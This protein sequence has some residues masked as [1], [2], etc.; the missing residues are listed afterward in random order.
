MTDFTQ[1]ARIHERGGLGVPLPLP[2]IDDSNPFFDAFRAYHE[3]EASTAN[4]AS[5]S[6][7]ERFTR[8]KLPQVAISPP[9]QI[10]Q[11]FLQL[12]Q[13]GELSPRTAR[14]RYAEEMHDENRAI[15]GVS[16]NWDEKFRLW[17][18]DIDALASVGE[19][20]FTWRD[21]A[22]QAY[23]RAENARSLAF[24][25]AP[26]KAFLGSMVAVFTDP[27]NLAAAG[28]SFALTGGIGLPA[29]M[30]ALGRT[31]LKVGVVEGLTNLGAEELTMRL[32]EENR[33][34]AGVEPLTDKEKNIRRAAAGA[35]G[36]VL[37]GAI[38]AGIG[39]RSVVRA[40][41]EVAEIAAEEIKEIDNGNYKARVSRETLE[42]ILVGEQKAA[43]LIDA[44]PTDDNVVDNAKGLQ[45]LNKAAQR[46]ENG[47]PPQVAP[48]VALQLQ[49][50]VPAEMKDKLPLIIPAEEIPQIQVD[51]QRFQLKD[52][53]AEGVVKKGG[54][55]ASRDFD[56]RSV[57]DAVIWVDA[58]GT[59]FIVD[60][61]QRLARYK[62]WVAEGRKD[63]FMKAYLLTESAGTTAEDAM[64]IAST[65]NLNEGSVDTM[66]ATKWLRG[67]SPSDFEKAVGYLPKDQATIK[68]S[69]GMV[70]LGREAFELVARGGYIREDMAA[71]VGARLDDPDQQMAALREFHKNPPTSQQHAH[72]LLDTMPFGL[73]S[74]IE[75]TGSLGFVNQA[76][77]IADGRARGDLM[78]A[79]TNEAA[80]NKK[81][82]SILLSQGDT[83]EG[84]GTNRLDTEANAEVKKN[85][86][87]LLYQIR[88]QAHSTGSS[89]N[90]A[91]RNGSAKLIKAKG[92]ER[93][94]LL[95]SIAKT[96]IDDLSSAPQPVGKLRPE[97]QQQSPARAS[98]TPS[99]ASEA[100][101][102]PVER[103]ALT[104]KPT[105]DNP[106]SPEV[107]E[108]KQAE[109]DAMLSRLTPEEKQADDMQEPLV[110]LADLQEEA[111]AVAK[112]RDCVNQKKAGD[113]EG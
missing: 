38:E 6:Y 83:I 2:D 75:E 48:E 53:D 22:A 69:L 78:N 89:I 96:A 74:E 70:G 85:A 54:I 59:R 97:D 7:K 57:G 100:P 20:P 34:T 87:A 55:Q 104:Y 72:L 41:R 37:G 88:R 93:R 28:V 24:D 67:L 3:T 44:V 84:W 40:R 77:Q 91:I 23:Q 5:K 36:F 15:M 10:A 109:Y 76:E 26:V 11:R 35:G 86:D 14:T 60:G 21:K 106:I 113:G 43:D 31:A 4:P 50:G 58:K 105:E 56:F 63:I 94:T 95:A 51:P 19:K 66:D 68:H 61:H 110:Q 29:T 112:L 25:E 99:S 18:Q 42:A 111:D 16:I 73:R 64:F 81:A 62:R 107:V 49:T 90:E 32:Q 9:D 12:V 92:K 17:Q 82:S 108:Q 1:Q 39:L 103:T 101:R 27:I 98:D 102:T 80:R 30:A 46:M 79:M 71:I 13:D 8:H 47:L 33:A 52:S 45:E 65:K